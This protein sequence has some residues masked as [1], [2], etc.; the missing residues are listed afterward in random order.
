MKKNTY[1]MLLLFPAVIFL[2][3]CKDSDKN[4][5]TGPGKIGVYKN[6]IY[7]GTTKKDVEGYNA[8]T[9]I[10]VTKGSI[11]TVL[12]TIYDNNLK[13]YFNATYEEVYTGNPVYIQQCR[14]NMRGMMAYGPSLIKTQDIDSVDCIARATWC[15]RK[16]KE[17]VKIALKDAKVDTSGAR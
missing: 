8:Y 3:S 5:V 6:G 12:W 9:S 15:C 10:E 2:L 17:V 4:S 7:E 1:A 16:F 13:R 14:D 11:A